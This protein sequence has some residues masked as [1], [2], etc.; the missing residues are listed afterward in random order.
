MAQ[1]GGLNLPAER[2]GLRRLAAEL[3]WTWNHERTVYGNWLMPKCGVEPR[4]PGSSC[5]G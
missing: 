1:F 2:A 5:K 3:R 4:A